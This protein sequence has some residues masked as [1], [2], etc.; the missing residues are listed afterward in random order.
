ME[1]ECIFDSLI[2]NQEKFEDITTDLFQFTS[3]IFPT[4][5][6]LDNF[7]PFEIIMIV[8]ISMSPIWETKI[9]QEN[10]WNGNKIFQILFMR[11]FYLGFSVHFP[12]F[13]ALLSGCSSLILTLLWRQWAGGGVIIWDKLRNL[14]IL[15]SYQPLKATLSF[16]KLY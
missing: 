15:A 9:F 13:L 14:A 8:H 4:I 2:S 16:P 12:I 5:H 1:G 11:Q 10:I 3:F 7:F 6:P